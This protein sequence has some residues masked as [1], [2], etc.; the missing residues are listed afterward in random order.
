MKTT[1]PAHPE[2]YFNELRPGRGQYPLINMQRQNRKP[3]STTSLPT[4]DCLTYQTRA[5]AL[6]GL[7]KY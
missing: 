7:M 1:T 3:E 4:S 5:S 2:L 6:S